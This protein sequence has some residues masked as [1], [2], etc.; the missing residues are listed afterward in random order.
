M[1]TEQSDISTYPEVSAF[2]ME[3]LRLAEKGKVSRNSS[4]GTS[5]TVEG[6]EISVYS[7]PFERKF[8]W[9][10]RDHPRVTK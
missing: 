10:F 2:L 7:R 3:T 8:Y 5:L 1:I 4:V 6:R 9:Y